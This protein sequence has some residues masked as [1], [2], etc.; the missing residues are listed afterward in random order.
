MEVSRRLQWLRN[1]LLLKVVLC[2]LVWGL[3]ALFAPPAVLALFGLEAPQ[4]PI[5]LRLFG[6]LALALGVAY[7]FAYQDPVKNEAI[8]KVGVV[9][10]G[11]ATLTVAVLGLTQ[12][13][14]S[15]FV[16]LSGA[17]T[18]FFTVAFVAL[19]PTE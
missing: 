14:S 2:F 7:W 11:L 10:N 4:D 16:W 1:L 18:A 8:V 3:P 13:I 6:A 12:G 19:M 9:D 17:L 5:F 15:W